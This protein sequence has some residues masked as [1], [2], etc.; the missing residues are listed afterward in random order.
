MTAAVLLVL[1]SGFLHAVW[2]LFTKKSVNKSAFLWCCQLVA[3]VVFLPWAISDLGKAQSVPPAYLLLA[4]SML[5]HGTY[6]VLLAKAYTLGDLSQVYPVMRG[7][8]PLL[9]PII[10][11]LFLNER[12]A[13]AGWAGVLLIVSG[14]AALSRHGSNAA[15]S[16]RAVA[17]AL[18]V[19]ICI[20]FYILVDKL[21]LQYMPATVLN[22]ATNIANL[23]ALSYPAAASGALRSEWKANW[24][25]VLLG[26]V[27]APGGYL[28]FLFALT[29]GQAA[30]LTPIREIGTVFG[31]LMGIYILNE[32][33]GGK[34]IAS[35]ILI[36]AG[37]VLL[38][39]TPN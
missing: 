13:A 27:A 6:M 8:G 12:L 28:L 1:S 18:A 25:T 11:V 24:R 15:A 14:I 19:G 17:A 7:M 33:Q 32:P 22:E 10:A 29:L 39:F 36:A 26:G 30:M 34:R 2:N 4:A 23:L 16:K 21:S 5:L 38:A 37:V 35:S 31:T 3:I 20:A 9:V